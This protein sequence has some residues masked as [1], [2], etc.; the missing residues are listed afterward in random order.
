MKTLDLIGYNRQ[1]LGKKTAKK[2]R[3]DS[4]VPCVLYGKE[5][6]EPLHFSVPMIL[7]R[8]LVYTPEVHFVK[9]DIEGDEHMCILQDV[10]FHPV[11]EIIMHADFLALNDDKT[12]KMDIPTTYS[13]TSPGMQKGGKLVTKLRK[14]KVEALPKDMP[15]KI[16]VS[17]EGLELGKSVKV[18][19]LEQ[20]SYTILN[21][22]LI[23]IATIEIPRALKSAQSKE[24]TEE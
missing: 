11:S 1:E 18:G 16:E 3:E 2:L 19:N 7:F 9:M 21:N 20:E 8:E 14:I 12:V 15:D 6:Q 10:Q 13:G 17:I 5:G 24:E 23:T 4:Q 22:P